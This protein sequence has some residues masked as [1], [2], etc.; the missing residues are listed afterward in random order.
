MQPREAE[1]ELDG[2]G[3]AEGQ[4]VPAHVVPAGRREHGA[5]ARAHHGHHGLARRHVRHGHRPVAREA[6]EPRL[7]AKARGGRGD[8]E[9][10]GLGQARDGH[11]R[12]DPAAG[13]EHLG[14]D[15]AARLD[16]RLGPAGEP[17]EIERV[18]ALDPELAEARQVVEPDAAPHG[19][20]LGAAV[21]PPRGAVPVVVVLRALAVVREPVG[22]LPAGE[23]AH[24]RAA[25]EE[26]A[27][28]RRAAH[29]A[30]GDLLAE[31]EVV[32]VEQ[33]ERLGGPFAKIP[34]VALERLHAGDVHVRQVEG[35]LAA[36]HP[37]R[38]CKPGTARR[39]DADRVEARGRPRVRRAGARA[40]VVG[41]VGR[42]ALGAVEEGVNARLPQ[43]RHAGDGAL[44][45]R[46][47]VV[48]VLG[49][50]VELEVL[51]DR[52]PGFRHRLE[53]AEQ[54]L[55]R[56]L[57]VV[58]AL[59]GHA[60][61]GQGAEIR[62]RLGDD[63]EVLAGLERDVRAEHPAEAPCPHA[64]AVDH[65]LA[66]DGAAV[67]APAPFDVGDAVALPADPRDGHVLEH[68]RAALP[69]A[70]RERQR[71]VRRVPLS[72]LR[73]PDG[74]RHIA[75]LQVRVARR[76]L[77]RGD[78]LDLHAP[79]ARHAGLTPDL[80]GAG[81]GQGHGD[82]PATAK[83]RRDA[84]LGLQRAVELLAVLRETR[85]GGRRAQ[86]RDETGGVPGGAGRQ[87]PALEQHRLPAEPGEVI[88]DRAADDAAADD[89]DAGAGGRGRGAHARIRARSASQTGPGR[90]VAGTASPNTSMA[91]SVPSAASPVGS[92]ASAIA[93]PLR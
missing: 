55:A 5:R 35:H 58:G 60:Q 76:H 90:T 20:V 6:P 1:A 2:A 43:H 31:R 66:G 38:Q 81:V 41:I 53:G 63:V 10:G 24:H 34:A 80:L 28:D 62:D 77:A 73:Q 11:V 32:G 85:H 16:V 27:V 71:D 23:L 46:L 17:Q 22:P 19:Q 59:V 18:A 40:E 56:V 44:E 65:V 61:D 49:E 26:L 7:V 9:E 91:R 57:L 13:V 8:H 84:G 92:I 42:E 78:L 64:G 52:A 47:E 33:T 67:L 93:L 3:V 37:L 69:G 70:L 36:V 29:A 68:L 4:G 39:L 14:V 15:D 51:G 83:A 86:L 30:R 72:V 79:G 12:L 74:A 25:L 45:D 21:G 54:H 82:R 89:D 88:R 48:E 75:G 87:A 50:L